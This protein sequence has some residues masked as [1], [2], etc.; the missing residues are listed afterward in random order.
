M[1]LHAA[2]QNFM[3]PVYPMPKNTGKSGVFGTKVRHDSPASTVTE[4]PAFRVRL[5]AGSSTRAPSLKGF[6]GRIKALVRKHQHAAGAAG[7]KRL[8]HFGR[9]ANAA[10]KHAVRAA[11]QRVAVK[12]RVVRHSTSPGANVSARLRKHIDYLKRDGV[13]EG[14]T[15]GVAFDADRDLT[16]Q[17]IA[18]FR[19][20]L[21]PDR[22][23][24]RFIVSPEHGARLDLKLYARE[25]VASMEGDLGTK[26]QWLGV[27][28]YDTDN[29]HLHLLVRGKDSQGADLVVN[30]E[31]ISHGMRLQAMEVATRYLGP[32]LQHEIEHSQKLELTADR[33]TPLDYQLAEASAQRPDGLVSAL[34]R[35]DGT[36]AS[37]QS[38]TRI[39]ARLQHLEELGLARELRPGIWRPETDLVNRLRGLASQG[40]VIKRLH[41]RMKGVPEDR[42]RPLR[43]ADIAYEREW[44][45]A[46]RRLA[47]YGEI[48]RLEAGSRFRGKVLAIE[49]LPSGAHAVVATGGKIRLIPNGVGLEKSIGKT[50]EFS[51]GR[52]ASV[53]PD[54]P[55]ALSLAIRH[56]AIGHRL[57]RR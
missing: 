12:A 14:A 32:R 41:E 2:A 30:R 56:R 53:A 39:I 42:S 18:A 44:Q 4:S 46:G 38:R 27:V 9:G 19:E 16:E 33:P 34:R 21:T 45:A 25:L 54:E 47:Q 28:H 24:F 20:A 55:T 43:A 35:P 52:A 36:P 6:A 10:A 13:A 11:R 48:E 3:Y 7:G 5:G 37:E 23:H 26:L 17:D 15:Q 40:D 29:P 31:Y 51:I 50:L 1:Q 22:H 8:S 57:P 49:S